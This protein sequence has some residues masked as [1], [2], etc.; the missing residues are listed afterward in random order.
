MQVSKRLGGKAYIMS[1]GV[2]KEKETRDPFCKPHP[3]REQKLKYPSQVGQT[4]KTIII[5]NKKCNT[6]NA[7]MCD[8]DSDSD[9]Q[10]PKQHQKESPKRKRYA[11]KKKLNKDYNLQ[12]IQFENESCHGK[13]L[14]V[15]NKM[16]S[17]YNGDGSHR[18]ESRL[19]NY[20]AVFLYDNLSSRYAGLLMEAR[21]QG[22]YNIRRGHERKQNRNLTRKSSSHSRSPPL[23]DA[24]TRVIDNLTIS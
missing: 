3:I 19:P 5:K 9:S 18:I 6:T 13:I 8:S 20:M 10:S 22:L 7:L 4:L 24:P 2:T 16:T 17:I 23:A 11:E 14:L 12:K 21:A 1:D 15:D